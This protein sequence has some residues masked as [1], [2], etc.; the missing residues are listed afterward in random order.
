MQFKIKKFY[1]GSLRLGSFQFLKVASYYFKIFKTNS[2]SLYFIRI[3]LVIHILGLFM[4]PFP[5]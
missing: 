1:I 4:Y 5:C 3:S 2:G